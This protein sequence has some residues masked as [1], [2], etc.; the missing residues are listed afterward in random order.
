MIHFNI[1]L[2]STLSSPKWSIP[3]RSLNSVYK[4]LKLRV[5]YIYKTREDLGLHFLLGLA[6]Y[7]GLFHFILKQMCP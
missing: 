5:G 6:Q 1:I 2:T 4:A 7:H 3:F